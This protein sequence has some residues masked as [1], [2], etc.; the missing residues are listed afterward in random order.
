[1]FVRGARYLPCRLQKVAMYFV[2][3]EVQGRFGQNFEQWVI[4]LDNLQ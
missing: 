1:M 2:D 4:N 3:L